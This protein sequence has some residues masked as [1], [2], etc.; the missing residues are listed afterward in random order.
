MTTLIAVNKNSHQHIKID[1]DQAIFHGAN[2]HLIPVVLSEFINLVVQY[3]IVITKNADTGQFVCS[4]MLG[5]EPNENLFFN[6][7]QW[8]SIY[9]P[10]QIQRQPFFIDMNAND[11]MENKDEYIVCFDSDSPAISQNKGEKLYNSLGEESDYYKNAKTCLMRLLQGERDNQLFITSIQ[12]MDL[13]QPLSLE[14]TF[15]NNKSSRLNGLYTINQE[16]LATLSKEQ[17]S[18][19]HALGLLQPIYTM[20]ASLGQIYAL[21]EKKNHKISQ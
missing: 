15:K 5:F 14:V 4:T 21:I 7:K 12:E 8:Q 3:P 17:I 19:L 9:L 16:K 13:L 2:L 18:K 1:P 6:N 10:L 20:I 11:D